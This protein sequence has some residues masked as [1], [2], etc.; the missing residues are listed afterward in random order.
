MRAIMC[1]QYGP[2]DTLVVE[3]IAAPSPGKDEVVVSVRAVSISQANVLVIA[4]NHPN[5]RELPFTP[6]GEIAGIVKQVG[7]GVTA[8]KPGDAVIGAA[9]DGG[10]AEEIVASVNRL[11]R[12]PQGMDFKQI[13]SAGSYATS[14][15]A[16]RDVAKLKTGETV[17]ILGA[18]GGVGLAAVDLAKQMGARVI[19]CASSQDKLDLCKKYGADDLINYEGEDFRAA[20]KKAGG[21]KGLDVVIDPVGGKYAD[22][23]VRGMGWGGRY[24]IIGFAGGFVPDLPL[25]LPLLKGCSVMGMSLHRLHKHDPKAA[26]ALRADVIKLLADGKIKPHVWA[27]YPLERTADAMN[28]LRLRKVLGKVIVTAGNA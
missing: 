14:L 26:S 5:K 8:F 19:A 24:V 3:D 20:V 16:L 23:A 4:N 11:H 21:D 1:R 12:L 6:G 22:P 10:C 9:R 15:H 2:P 25:N 28:D 7:E 17:L 18:A 13:I 27:T